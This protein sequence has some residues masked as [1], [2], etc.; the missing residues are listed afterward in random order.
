[1]VI[2]LILSVV[3]LSTILWKIETPKMLKENLY[4]EMWTFSILLG[5][6]TILTILKI[7]DVDVPN[8]SDWIAW[9]YSPFK[10]IMQSLLK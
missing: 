5:I 4:R 8:P 6:G 2:V 3:V 9:V 7:L 10:N 1:M